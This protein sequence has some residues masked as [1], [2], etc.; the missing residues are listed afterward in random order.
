MLL[1]SIDEM[2]ATYAAVFAA[3]WEACADK[4]GAKALVRAEQVHESLLKDDITIQRDEVEHALAC[5][6]A[7]YLLEPADGAWRLPN[8]GLGLLLMDEELQERGSTWLVN[9]TQPQPTA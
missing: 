9:A 2:P 4:R 6:H 7:A 3:A 5:L 1:V 8:G